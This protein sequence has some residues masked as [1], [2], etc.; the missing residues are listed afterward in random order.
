[1]KGTVDIRW[2]ITPTQQ[3]VVASCKRTLRSHSVRVARSVWSRLQSRVIECRNFIVEVS[4]LDPGGTALRRALLTKCGAARPASV[5]GAEGCVDIPG[6]WESLCLPVRK[7]TG[8]GRSRNKT[9]LA[10]SR[11]SAAMAIELTEAGRVLTS[12]LKTSWSGSGTG[13]LS[14]LIVAF[15]N[16]E[17]FSGGSQ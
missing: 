15:E 12:K 9:S 5:S 11:A 2:V 16:W 14:P 3:R 6:T 7:I 8:L 13:S 1:M 10:M 17:T 4:L